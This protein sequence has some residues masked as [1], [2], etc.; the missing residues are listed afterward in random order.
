M[1][2]SSKHHRLAALLFITVVQLTGC[3]WQQQ[4]V[5]D[6]H[7]KTSRRAAVDTNFDAVR[8]KAARTASTMVGSPYRYGGKT[9]AGFDCSGL[10]YFSYQEAGITVPRTS[11]AQFKATEQID[12]ADARPGDLLFFRERRKIS[13]VAIYL[14]DDRFVHAPSTGKKVSITS[15]DD[16]YYRTHFVQAGRLNSG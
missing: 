16:P 12:L 15:L 3:S 1:C 7:A 11:A 4:G 8:L 6:P 13:H 14:G 5:V 10:V 9:P 2:K